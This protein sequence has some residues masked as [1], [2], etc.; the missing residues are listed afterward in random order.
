M[1]RL[2]KWFQDNDL[3]NWVILIFTG[4]FWP[5]ILYLLNKRKRWFI[6]GLKTTLYASRINIGG[7]QP[8][9]SLGLKLTNSTNSKIFITNMRIRGNRKNLEIN[10]SST[11]DIS[12]G[13]YELLFM[14][15]NAH[16]AGNTYN[17]TLHEILLHTNQ[18]IETAIGLERELNTEIF[19]YWASFLRRLLGFPKYFVIEYTALVGD[20]KYL[21]KTIY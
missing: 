11:Y 5:I 14:D 1:L 16:N 15:L 20:R 8:V 18:E 4:I 17:Y 3:P 13:Y 10:R 7:V 21:V 6:P 2:Y 19:N 9:P 12:T